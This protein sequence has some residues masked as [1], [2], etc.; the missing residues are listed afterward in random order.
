MIDGK[1]GGGTKVTGR[2]GRSRK[3]LL[4][5]LKERRVYWEVKEE[6]LDRTVWWII[7][8]KTMDLSLRK[9]NIWKNAGTKNVQQVMLQCQVQLIYSAKVS[10]FFSI[11]LE[12][13]D[14]FVP[15]CYE[16]NDSVPLEICF[17]YSQ[18]LK[19][20]FCIF[21]LD[22][23]NASVFQNQLRR[24]L[25]L[26][27]IPRCAW[28]TGVIIIRDAQLFFSISMRNFWQAGLS[29][30]EIICLYCTVDFVTG[31]RTAYVKSNIP[32][33]LQMRCS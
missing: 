4:D 7:F 22:N 18:Q 17:W 10:L 15:F 8:E 27:I 29:Q 20:G 33:C 21:M 28:P 32:A 5:D 3:Q 1:I 6:A 24:S 13:V 2:Q 12:H 25:C 30:L 31:A 11:T 9:N 23:S 14:A 16:F 26:H 19:N